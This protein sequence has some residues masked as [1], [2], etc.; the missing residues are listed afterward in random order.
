MGKR[1]R[2]LDAALAC[3]LENGYE[4]T[5]V[6]K[7]TQRSGVSNGA[8]F[9]YFS[10]KEAIAGALY[11]ETMRSVQEGHRALLR[12]R[13]E[14]LAAGVGATIAHQLQWTQDN[15]GPARFLYAQG[16]LEAG[17]P[18]AAELAELNRGLA[19][20]Y[21]AWMRPLVERGE[22]RQM[23]MVMFTAIV[24]GPAHA[25]A[26]RWLAGQLEAPLTSYVDELADAAVAGLTGSPV[27]PG[28]RPR[29]PAGGG[30]IRVQLL[31]DDGIVVAEGEAIAGLVDAD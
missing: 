9:H 5:T 10:S 22:V 1:E 13:P 7:I 27:E 20:D 14:S 4:R 18:A 3:F 23:S 25:V 21:R 30:R 29:Q 15:V 28:R 16:H 2:I 8:V 17:S 11:V 24:T 26:Q 19:E 12:S 6:A 31:S